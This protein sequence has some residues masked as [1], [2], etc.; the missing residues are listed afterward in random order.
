MRFSRSRGAL[1]LFPVVL[2]ALA[3]GVAQGNLPCGPFLDIGGA[4]PFCAFVLEIFYMG[5]T[6]GTTPTT[7]DPTSNVTR[8]QMAAFL[9]R[10]VDRTLQR[11]SRRAALRQYWTTQSVPVLG[12]TTVGDNPNFVESDGADLWVANF[13]GDSVSR[14]RGKRPESPSSTAG[15]SS[16]GARPESST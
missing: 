12:I 16:A 6:T 4:D 11:G 15:S 13:N 9:S 14:V 8:V 3:A 2:L 5:I 1:G 10:T 7:Y